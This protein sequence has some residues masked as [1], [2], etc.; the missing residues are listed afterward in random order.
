MQID[1]KL[2]QSLKNYFERRDDISFAFLFGSAARGRVRRK[3]KQSL[4]I[5][6]SPHQVQGPRNDRIW[7]FDGNNFML[8]LMI[9]NTDVLR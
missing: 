1:K 6:T 7:P 3:A 2:L 8:P 5:A 4:E 9:L